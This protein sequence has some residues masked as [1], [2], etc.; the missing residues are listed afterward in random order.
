MSCCSELD[1]VRYFQSSPVTPL[2]VTTVVFTQFPISEQL[3]SLDHTHITANSA[4][5]GFGSDVHVCKY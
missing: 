5:S 3:Q 4:V 2:V 1:K